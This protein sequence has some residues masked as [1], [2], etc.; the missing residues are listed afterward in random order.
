MTPQG[1]PLFEAQ[2]N[3]ATVLAKAKTARGL[4]ASNINEVTGAAD[5]A[6][7]GNLDLGVD[8]SNIFNRITNDVFPV[9]GDIA[10]S[11]KLK[12][13]GI[14]DRIKSKPKLKFTEANQI[15]SEITSA[16]NLA[17]TDLN[18]AEAMSWTVGGIFRDEI[19]SG[20]GSVSTDLAKKFEQ[21]SR[22]YG[23]WELVRS[24]LKVPAQSA[25]LTHLGAV[26]GK[27]LNAARRGVLATMLNSKAG[28]VGAVA[29]GLMSIVK[30]PPAH[31]A[32]KQ[33]ASLAKIANGLQT[34]PGKY[35]ELGSRLVMA[36]GRSHA[37]FQKELGYAESVMDL[38]A[39]PIQRN[40]NDLVLK[41]PQALNVV[42]DVSPAHGQKLLAAVQSGNES[43][44]GAI[45]SELGRMQAAQGLI[46]KGTGW[47]GKAATVQDMKDWETQIRQSPQNHTTKMR[48]LEELRKFGTGP[49][50]EEKVDY[51]RQTIISK[52]KNGRKLPR[53]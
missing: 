34:A 3:F 24:L 51:V 10:P 13:V 37:Y 20:L 7:A 50:F 12:V 26:Q 17:K 28:M 43:E 30:R 15:R 47:N 44:I 40:T 38:H 19:L 1:A 27:V 49:V 35:Q 29:E 33:L 42:N 31:M 5:M 53:L 6:M 14:L 25:N 21:H 16:I 41:L 46:A 9:L 48:Q 22:A 32:G 52:R 11:T 8:T 2:D 18:N 39:S 23:N 4:E 45:M 36:A